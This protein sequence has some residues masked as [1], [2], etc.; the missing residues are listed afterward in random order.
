MQF[1]LKSYAWNHKYDIRP[2]LHSTQFSY[3]FIKSIF[4][5]HN[6][7]ALNFR[8]WC[9]VPSWA[10][11]CHVTKTHSSITNKQAVLKWERKQPLSCMRV[12]FSSPKSMMEDLYSFLLWL[13]LRHLIVFGEGILGCSRYNC[14]MEFFWVV[15]LPRLHDAQLWRVFYFKY[16][17]YRSMALCMILRDASPL[18]SLAFFVTSA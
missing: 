6:F 8:F 14:A 3:H 9:N 13:K 18:V 2:K 12:R 4:K 7:M 17:E 16:P 1:G 11:R 5:S 10:K 15:K